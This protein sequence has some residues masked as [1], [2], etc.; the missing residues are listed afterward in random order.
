MISVKHPLCFL[1]RIFGDGMSIKYTK[2]L[3]MLIVFSL[4]QFSGCNS[5]DESGKVDNTNKGESQ[6]QDTALSPEEILSAT[7]VQGIAGEDDD[8]DLEAFIEEDLYG[9]LKNSKA[10]TIDRVSSSM[11]VIEFENLG[12]TKS[13]LIRKFYNP[14]KDEYFFEKTTFESDIK[15]QFLK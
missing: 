4:I 15:K 5:K 8:P 6:D 12:Q 13:Y 2:I 7:L 10:V 3:I 9:E 14:Q 1:N 11:Y